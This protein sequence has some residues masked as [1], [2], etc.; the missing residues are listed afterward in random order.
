MNKYFVSDDR[1]AIVCSIQSRSEFINK[2]VV[3]GAFHSDV[4]MDVKDAFETIEY[5]QA[6]AYYSW[7]LYD[8]AFNKSLRVLE[9]AIKQKANQMK[10]PLINKQKNGKVWDKSLGAL[11]DEICEKPQH[12]IF[13]DDLCRLRDLRNIQMHPDHYSFMG[14]T[15]RIKHN[16]LLVVNLINMLFIIRG[17]TKYA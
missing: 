4:P 7:Q 17:I 2:Y 5:L 16:I 1:W 11:I 15:G 10:I 9:I 3:E 13:Y 14:A 12:Q 6:H 8:E